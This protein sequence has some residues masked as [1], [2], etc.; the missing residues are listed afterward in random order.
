MVDSPGKFKVLLLILSCVITAG[1]SATA[2]QW[3]SRTIY[4]VLTDRFAR[5]DGATPGCSNL[6]W[7]CGGGYVGLTNHLDYIQG[8]GFDAIWISPIID[9]RDGGYHGYWGRNINILNSNFGS[10]ANF[11]AFVNAC[12]SRGIWVMLDVV[13]NHMGNLDTTYTQNV[14]FNSSDHYHPFCI[15][16]D[17]DFATKNQDH[18]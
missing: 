1:K 6:G 4:Q 5:N 11:V 12:H 14:P 3:K 15:I 13:A 2:E 10:E 17:N 8:M 7:Y 16:T 18:I 9:N